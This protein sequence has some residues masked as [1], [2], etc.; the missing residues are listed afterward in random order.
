MRLEADITQDRRATGGVCEGDVLEPDF[1][2]RRPQYPGIVFFRDGTAFVQDPEEV[3][4]RRQLEEQRGHERRRGLQA[5]DQQHGEAH[6]ADDLTH[7]RHAVMC[8]QV[9][10]TTIEITASVLDARVIT[11]TSAH[12]LSTGNWCL[13][14]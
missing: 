4:Q 9:P 12:Q 3:L 11:F 2:S 7:A 10:T 8:N 13:I 5:A 14:T 6:E 1:A